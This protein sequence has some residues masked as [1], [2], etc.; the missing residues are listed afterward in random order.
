MGVPNAQWQSAKLS[1][2][3]IH[4]YRTYQQAR[5]MQPDIHSTYT[6]KSDSYIGP[7]LGSRTTFGQFGHV[8]S[9]P[10]SFYLGTTY[11]CIYVGLT[12]IHVCLFTMCFKLGFFS[13]FPRLG[14]LPFLLASGF[15]YNNQVSQFSVWIGPHVIKSP[16]FGCKRFLQT[17]LILEL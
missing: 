15:Q 5:L 12:H 13:S 8:Q 6:F 3:Y 11:I 7:G 10:H 16:E 2:S 17:G 9:D 1:N 14:F 4:L